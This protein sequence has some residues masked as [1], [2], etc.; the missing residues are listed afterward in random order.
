MTPWLTASI[1]IAK[2]PLD[3]DRGRCPPERTGASR[4]GYGHRL[5]RRRRACTPGHDLPRIARVTLW[6][7]RSKM[8]DNT[9]KMASAD[10]QCD[11]LAQA[12]EKGYTKK[13]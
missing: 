5:R 1:Q 8:V 2:G 13:Y 4:T 12:K 11:S 7:P 6:A 10:A 3:A 9:E